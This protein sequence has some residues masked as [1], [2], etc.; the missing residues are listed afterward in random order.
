MPMD[1]G[2]AGH[3]EKTCSALAGEESF[4][5]FSASSSGS[6]T[7]LT[8]A[9]GASNNLGGQHLKLLN[10]MQKSWRAALN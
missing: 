2:L 4:G 8:L 10:S 3:M 9:S 6:A 7:I 5:S 1:K